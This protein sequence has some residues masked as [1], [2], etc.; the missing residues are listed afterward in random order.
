MIVHLCDG[1]GKSFDNMV[2]TTVRQNV[3]TKSRKNCF[4]PC[5]KW[6]HSTQSIGEINGGGAA[7]NMQD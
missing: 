1:A 7:I 3:M 6:H 5:S 2:E 4:M